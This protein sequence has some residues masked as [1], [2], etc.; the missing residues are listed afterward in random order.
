MGRAALDQVSPE[1]AQKINL[2][3][4]HHAGELRL[5]PGHRYRIDPQRRTFV[6]EPHDVHPKK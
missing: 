6:A 4:F 2:A 1:L 5:K 3:V